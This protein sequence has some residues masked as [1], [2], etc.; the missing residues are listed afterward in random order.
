[1]NLSWYFEHGENLPTR[2]PNRGLGADCW[3]NQQIQQMNQSQEGQMSLLL[4]QVLE[5][6]EGDMLNINAAVANSAGLIRSVDNNCTKI[7]YPTTLLPNNI[8][9]EDESDSNDDNTDDDD[10]TNDDDNKEKPPKFYK[11]QYKK[12]VVR[13][14]DIDQTT[15]KSIT[16]FSCLLSM[17][18]YIVVVHDGNLKLIEKTVS[19]LTWFEEWMIFFRLFMVV[20]IIVG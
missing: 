5:Q 9:K 2:R 15:I 14:N 10:N 17:L 12:T 18:S 7:I 1:V 13:I 11:K 19:T 20:I 6:Q 3:I 8:T 16:G 4:S